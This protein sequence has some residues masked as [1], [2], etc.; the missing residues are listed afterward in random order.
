MAILLIVLMLAMFGAYPI[1]KADVVIPNVTHLC[2]N[3]YPQNLDHCPTN[4]ID[5]SK[6]ITI[7]NS[8]CT[9]TAYA[10]LINQALA[11]QGLH[12]KKTDGSQGPIISY[13]PADLN[14]LLND[15]QYQQPIYKVDANG[16]TDGVDHIETKCGWGTGKA[17][18]GQG[19]LTIGTDGKPIGSNTDISLGA[20]F[21]AVQ[22]DTKSKSFEGKGL[23]QKAGYASGYNGAP[24]IDANGVTLDDKYT[25]VLDELEAGMPVIVRTKNDGHTVL[26]TSFHQTPGQA[27][28]LGRYDIADPWNNPDGSSIQWLDDPQYHNMIWSWGADVFQKGGHSDPYQAPGDYY[29][30]PEYLNDSQINPD[31]YGPQ[32]SAPSFLHY[33]LTVGGVG[34]I[35]F[36]VPVDKL[37]LLAPYIGLASTAM[38]GAVATAVYVKRIKRRKE[39]Q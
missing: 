12:Q 38:I 11:A 14:T 34:G 26:V 25:K 33:P 19:A 9:L 36:S 30:P 39:K 27:R 29:V 17:P 3:D 23:T 28:G 21:K 2:Q 16:K 32:L 7:A 35:S 31:Q 24:A 13:T 18:S 20:L 1:V 15:Y 5:P 22:S 6:T 10:M 8:G 37:G 4:T